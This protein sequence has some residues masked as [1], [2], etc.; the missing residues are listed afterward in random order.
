MAKHPRPEHRPL[1]LDASHW[2]ADG[3]PK[4]RYRTR[5][6]AL[7]AAGERSRDAGRTLGVYECAFCRGWHM[8]KRRD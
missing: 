7:S 8:G 5:Q 2:R 6:Q 1:T 3:Q 4:V